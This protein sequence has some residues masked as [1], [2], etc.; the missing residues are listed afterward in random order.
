VR[1]W[2]TGA[3]PRVK[4]GE[5]QPDALTAEAALAAM[6]ADPL[7][8]RRPLMESGERREAGFDAALVDA[9]VGLRPADA[10]GSE[11]CLRPHHD[12]GGCPAPKD[13]TK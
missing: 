13:T 5:V 4:S 3:S 7:L 1:E 6:V 11:A 8:I 9:W 2:F 10:P 12:E